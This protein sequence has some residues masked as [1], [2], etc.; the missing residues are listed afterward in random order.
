MQN[1]LFKQY[2]KNDTKN[3]KSLRKKQISLIVT[4]VEKVNAYI[5]LPQIQEDQNFIQNIKS[6]IEAIS[7]PNESII[8]E[9]ASN[10]LSSI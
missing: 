6:S 5:H 1:E 7:I 3:E 10:L 8:S 2:L 9:K 4:I